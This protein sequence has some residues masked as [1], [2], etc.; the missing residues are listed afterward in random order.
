MNTTQHAWRTVVRISR[1]WQTMRDELVAGQD[2]TPRNAWINE[3]RTLLD[4]HSDMIEPLGV[5]ASGAREVPWL[6]L[7]ELCANVHHRNLARQIGSSM[8]APTG[9]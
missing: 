5:H 3:F 8:K 6:A 4:E 1:Q 2:Q 7:S 9:S